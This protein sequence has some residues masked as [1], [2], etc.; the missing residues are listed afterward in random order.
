MPVPALVAERLGNG[1][2]LSADVQGVLTCGNGDHEPQRP[3]ENSHPVERLAL[4]NEPRLLASWF[5][6]VM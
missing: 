4:Y 3:G 1:S 6:N 5:L 2:G